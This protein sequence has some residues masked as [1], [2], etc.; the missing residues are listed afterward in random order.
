MS[1]AGPGPSEPPAP[2]QFFVDVS[3]SSS[4]SSTTHSTS[5]NVPQPTNQYNRPFVH[6]WHIINGSSHNKHHFYKS[7]SPHPSLAAKLSA[8]H[9][10]THTTGHHSRPHAPK[11]TTTVTAYTYGGALSDTTAASGGGYVAQPAASAMS[12]TPPGDTIVVTSGAAPRP[13]VIVTLLRPVSKMIAAW[14]WV[15]GGWW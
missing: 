11:W 2:L 15:F 12:T 5:P 4:P 8:W 9:N 13:F 10:H 1:T 3:N 6:H 7:I 14:R